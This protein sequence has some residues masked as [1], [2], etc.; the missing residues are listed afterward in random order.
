MS[1]RSILHTSRTLA[2]LSAY[3]YA[4]N[5]R[6]EHVA[7]ILSRDASTIHV[8]RVAAGDSLALIIETPIEVVVVFR[9]TVTADLQS[10]RRDLRV[11]MEQHG[12]YQVH[13]GFNAAVESMWFSI[14]DHIL[15]A[16]QEKKRP[17]WFT[18]HSLGG[19]LAAITAVR[20]IQMMID[21]G[22]E[23]FRPAGLVTFGAPRCGDRYFGAAMDWIRQSKAVVA[24]F[25][26]SNDPVP[27]VPPLTWGYRHG[28]PEFYLSASGSIWFR[29][30][31]IRR[32]WDGL[33]E[34][35][36]KRYRGRLAAHSATRYQERVGS[37]LWESSFRSDV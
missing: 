19:A 17:L 30:N 14:A 12:I 16:Q 26:S 11:E 10:I 24:R 15:R 31:W 21:F 20:S 37:Y 6:D 22:T 1:K 35:M 23:E 2:D 32:F 27:F 33:F 13:A 3:A 9:G 5:I 4:T 36:S 34:R 8:H 7:R 25:T 28:I 29:P 18:G